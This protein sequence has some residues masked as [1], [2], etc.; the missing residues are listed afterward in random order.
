M[1]RSF[2]LHLRMFHLFVDTCEA[3]NRT[4]MKLPKPIENMTGALAGIIFL[5]A[6]LLQ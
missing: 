1:Y 2:K 6:K 3:E 4:F 5:Q